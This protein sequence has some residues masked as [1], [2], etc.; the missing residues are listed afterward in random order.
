MPP[1]AGGRLSHCGPPPP[2]RDR[3]PNSLTNFGNAPGSTGHLMGNTGPVVS[4]MQNTTQGMYQ[5]STNSKM[6]GRP[7]SASGV[8]WNAIPST[9]TAPP[10]NLPSDMMQNQQNCASLPNLTEQSV[11]QSIDLLADI[12]GGSSSNQNK[13]PMQNTN[14]NNA[15]GGAFGAIM[16]EQ[17]SSSMPGGLNNIEGSG[18]YSNS[19]SVYM[20][21]PAG[22]VQ[23]HMSVP[24]ATT[25]LDSG[26]PTSLPNVA[27]PP[28]KFGIV[29][30]VL[31]VSFEVLINTDR[32]ATAQGKQ[33]T[34]FLL[35]PD[36][37][38]TG[39]FVVVQGKFFET[40]GKYF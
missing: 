40:W 9:T 28:R 27:D 2:G 25:L 39:N 14:T 30:L 19:Q 5:S 24:A 11:N 13:P 18:A 4:N 36:R 20:N 31:E 7:S 38:N 23:R 15:N 26:R 6:P 35:L 22:G 8:Q 1:D 34:W 37:K 3:A 16:S 33:R 29:Y 12:M 17:L 21:G 32:V 10:N